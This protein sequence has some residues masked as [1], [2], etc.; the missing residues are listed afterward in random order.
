MQMQRTLQR[1]SFEMQQEAL[2]E[3]E[4]RDA[5]RRE[6]ERLAELERRRLGEVDKA[7]KAA[8]EEQRETIL[9]GE[10]EALGDIEETGQLDEGVNMEGVQIER[11]DYETLDERP[12]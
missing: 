5:A 12:E 8:E 7:Q 2:L 1:E 4:E 3:A 6:E 10:A 9:M 11:P